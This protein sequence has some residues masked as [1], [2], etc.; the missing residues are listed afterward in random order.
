MNVELHSC[1]GLFGLYVNGSLQENDE[2]VNDEMNEV[3]ELA[4]SV[5]K[6]D[7]GT[8][9]NLFA[10]INSNGSFPRRLSKLRSL[11]GK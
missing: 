2:E 9:G 6:E 4:T 8:Y 11:I 1:D 3:I 5:V 10:H 7:H